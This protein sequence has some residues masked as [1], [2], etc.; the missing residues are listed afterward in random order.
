MVLSKPQT[1]IMAA[2]ARTG[3][4][5]VDEIRRAYPQYNL[6]LKSLVTNGLVKKMTDGRYCLTE[7]GGT[8]MPSVLG[9]E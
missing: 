4:A 3:L 5:T 7:A 6:S 2:F 9:E 1:L 8:Y